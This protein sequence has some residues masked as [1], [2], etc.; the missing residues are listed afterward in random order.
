VRDL[1]VQHGGEQLNELVVIQLAVV[2][3]VELG[4]WGGHKTGLRLRTSAH[5]TQHGRQHGRT[6]AIIFWLCS[7]TTIE[8]FELY[9]PSSTSSTAT[10]SNSTNP[11]LS[12]HCEFTD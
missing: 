4:K 3:G 5:K 1:K 8:I 11:S 9:L 12:V 7:S 10:Q 2:V 6:S